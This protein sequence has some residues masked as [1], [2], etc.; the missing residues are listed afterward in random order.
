MNLSEARWGAG[1]FVPVLLE[2]IKRANYHVQ[3]A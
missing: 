3:L 1:N 2:T